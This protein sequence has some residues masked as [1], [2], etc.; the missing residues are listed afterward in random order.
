[1]CGT[2]KHCAG[3]NRFIVNA[4]YREASTRACGVHLACAVREMDKF[5]DDKYARRTIDSGVRVFPIKPE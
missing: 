1:M 2:A 3:K 5:N 4:R